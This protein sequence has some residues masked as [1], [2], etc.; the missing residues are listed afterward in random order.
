MHGSP[1]H[2][3]SICPV[4]CF[5]AIHWDIIA[6]ADRAILRDTS[7]PARLDPKPGG[8]ATNVAR[9]LSKLDIDT[10]LIGVTGAD[11]AALAIQAQLQ[12]DGITSH[13]Q[14]RQGFDT[15][16]YL[17]LHDPDGSLT[18]ACIDDQVLS[19]ASMEHFQASANGLPKDAL[20]LLDANLPADI[21]EGL[22]GL[23]PT[24]RLVA[25]AV[26]IAKAP[27]LKSVLPKLSLLILNTSEAAALTDLPDDTQAEKLSAILLDQGCSAVVI[28]A[29]AAPLHYRTGTTTGELH[30]PS[31]EIVDVTGAGD[32]LI[33]GT[34]AG[35]ARG[36]DLHE[37]LTYGQ[38][39]ALITLQAS[40]AAPDILTWAAMSKS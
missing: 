27:R 39:A 24:A 36:A 16:Q 2:P 13:I 18:A 26:S 31:A 17:A 15:G 37:A 21:L 8:V 1:S 5:G 10:H 3:A 6:H 29:G 35:L 4:A 34:L 28:T 19:T 12:R 25:D 38:K 32:A 20:W 40:G 22:A 14:E 23:A 9:T 7:T 11:P 30:S 33:A